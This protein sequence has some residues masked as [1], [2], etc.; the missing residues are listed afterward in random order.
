MSTE[1]VELGP[2]DIVVIGYPPGAP[3][4]GEA[5]PLFLDLV[6]KG[7]IRVLDV[8]VVQKDEDGTISGLAVSDL[9][10]DGIGDLAVFEGATSGLIGDEDAQT[11]GAEIEP[12]TAAVIICY[13]N[14]W[15]APFAAAVR[16]N[17]GRMIAFERVSAQDLLDTLDALEAAEA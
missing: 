15:A 4:T 1:D 10:A 13:E 5:L 3:K 7:T 17:G 6:E 2:I 12:G 16:R 8:L 11:A 9:D 14:A